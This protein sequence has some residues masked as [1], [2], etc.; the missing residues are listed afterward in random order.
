M[1]KQQQGLPET[2]GEYITVCSD[3]SLFHP[4]R[5]DTTVT[6]ADTLDYKTFVVMKYVEGENKALPIWY[7]KSVPEF[8]RF[9]TGHEFMKSD[10]YYLLH[11]HFTVSPKPGLPANSPLMSCVII[12]R[13]LLTEV[14][15][16]DCV[17]QTQAIGNIDLSARL[18]KYGAKYIIQNLV[19]S[20]CGW[21][22]HKEGD[23]G[24]LHK[25][26][27]E[28][29]TPLIDKMY[30]EPNDRMIVPL[31]NWKDTDAVWKRKK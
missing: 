5:L 2:E 11:N 26:Q 4:K 20:S 22:P 16:W 28:D 13:Q 12:S 14:G 23:H 8:L 25:A 19:C 9:R 18:M 1:H 24:P 6:L 30:A 27:L 29:D 10:V 7:L 15:G 21:M 31:D 17:F 3:D